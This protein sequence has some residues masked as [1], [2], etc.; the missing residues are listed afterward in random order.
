MSTNYQGLRVVSFESRR[1]AETAEL[2]ARHGGVATSAPSMR[3][4]PLDHHP[5]AVEF[6]QRLTAGDIDVV[7]LLTG[8]GTNMLAR[9]VEPVCPRERFAAALKGVVTVARGPKPVAALRE[10]GLRPTHLVPEPNTWE[11]L[12]ALLDQKQPVGGKRVAVQEYGKSNGRLLAGL[13]DRGADVFRVPIYQ[14]ALPHDLGPLRAAIEAIIA[15]DIDVALF[16]S[17]TQVDHLF[18]VADQDGKSAALRDALRGVCI[19]SIGPVASEAIAEAGLTVDY[20]P[21]S[22][23]LANL[24]RETARRGRDLL[25][26]KHVAAAQG[27]DTN[28]WR[29]IDMVWA[30]PSGVV[31]GVPTIG[32]SV[33]MKACRLEPVP[34]TPVW[35]MR[36]AGRYQAEYRKIRKGA[37][38]IE[39]C[40][41]P[42]LAA[43]VTLMAVERLGVDAAIIFSDIL[44]VIESMGFQLEYAK[45]EG[46]VIHNPLHDRR[47]LDRVKAGDARELD[48]VYEAVRLTR[49]ALRPDVALIGFCGAPFT[50]A[51]YVVEG[52][53]SSHYIATKTLMHNDP[54]TWHAFIEKLT[55]LLVGYL[56]GQIDAGAD[57]VQVFDSWVGALSPD[58]YRAYVLPHMKRLF[59]GVARAHPATP[60]IH[61]GTGNPALLPLMK[62]A[63]GSVIGLDWRV[64]L[65]DAWAML[66]HD[67]AVMG[68]L[69]PIVLYASTSEIRR[70]TRAILEKAAGRPGHIFNL[71]HGILPDMSPEHVAELVDAVRELSA[72]G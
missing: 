8:V 35:L 33:F 30:K 18:Q 3:E 67:T 49:R 21:D 28:A 26:K 31:T 37:S 41:S 60:T 69:D 32:D 53:K 68:N 34:Y 64:D 72:R 19:G 51:S 9:A 66:G 11:D 59:E 16:T 70:Q 7:V 44:L 45:G 38:L 10:L 4:A 65:A 43:E 52:G 5:E 13:R 27:I 40:K 57:A 46:P 23:H 14:W 50:I 71:G 39:L 22:P 63:G 25:T 12:L 29:R 20:E 54:A 47:D 2:I 61:F 36:Q 48:F 42:R 55:E 6:A 62:E 17:A 15:G 1:A 24:V 56:N 58:D